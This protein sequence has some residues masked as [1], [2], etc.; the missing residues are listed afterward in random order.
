MYL[1]AI[2]SNFS[3]QKKP[4]PKIN[5]KYALSPLEKKIVEMKHLMSKKFDSE[6]ISVPKFLLSNLYLS[7][8]SITIEFFDIIS[9]FPKSNNFLFII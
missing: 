2:K 3:K 5:N 6:N 9:S 8:D 1:K 4:K 7:G